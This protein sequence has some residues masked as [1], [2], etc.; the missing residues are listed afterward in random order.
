MKSPK[1]PSIILS[2]C[3]C[4]FLL[5]T[6]RARADPSLE[7]PPSTAEEVAKL[8]A[9]CGAPSAAEL[10]YVEAR[11][12]TQTPTTCQDCIDEYWAKVEGLNERGRT[13]WFNGA[14]F[15][16]YCL[17]TTGMSAA[18]ITHC[19]Q[20]WQEWWATY[21]ACKM[22]QYKGDFD[23]C[24]S[25]VGGG[26]GSSPPAMPNTWPP[27]NPI[28]PTDPTVSSPPGGSCGSTTCNTCLW[29]WHNDQYWLA[30]EYCRAYDACGADQQCK[31]DLYAWYGAQQTHLFNRYAGCLIASSCSCSEPELFWCNGQPGAWCDTDDINSF[32]YGFCHGTPPSYPHPANPTSGTTCQN[33]L[34]PVWL[35]PI[36]ACGTE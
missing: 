17:V 4:L 25:T 18:D 2:L 9:M 26:C 23:D 24:C 15:P 13:Y 3:L 10:A 30:F 16:T 36:V 6:V 31:D 20:E 21:R 29:Y 8:V 28:Q 1:R 22:L 19:T 11:S 34:A 27:A 32:A 35:C 33:V 12:L 5:L 7:R 14:L